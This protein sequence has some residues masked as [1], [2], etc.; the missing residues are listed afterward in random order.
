MGLP[1]G[2]I[3]IRGRRTEI[4]E[5]GRV[6][7]SWQQESDLKQ[8]YLRAAAR[9]ITDGLGVDDYI[10]IDSWHEIFSNDRPARRYITEAAD[11]DAFRRHDGMPPPAARTASD[12]GSEQEEVRDQWPAEANSEQ[13]DDDLAEEEPEVEPPT[14]ASQQA[15]DDAVD[16]PLPLPSSGPSQTPVTS[17]RKRTAAALS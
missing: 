8:K 7:I 1:P 13:G 6:L 3:E 16:E 10:I 4:A 17:S 12:G 5:E 15:R 11:D 14:Q 9:V 2:R